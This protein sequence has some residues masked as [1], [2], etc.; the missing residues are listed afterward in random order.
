MRTGRITRSRPVKPDAGADKAAQKRAEPVHPAIIS[1][2]PPRREWES[3]ISDTPLEPISH[4]TI[5]HGNH[6]KNLPVRLLAGR[7][8]ECIQPGRRDEDS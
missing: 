4:T 3:M 6:G 8:F 7:D 1:T 5:S 2:N